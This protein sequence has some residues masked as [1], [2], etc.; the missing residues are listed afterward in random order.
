MVADA[1]KPSVVQL[2]P[3][4]NK[5]IQRH[6]SLKET[7]SSSAG[8]K[9]CFPILAVNRSQSGISED[10]SIWSLETLNSLAFSDYKSEVSD[11]VPYSGRT[12]T[13][14]VKYFSYIVVVSFIGGGNGSTSRTSSIYHKLLT[15]F[16][17]SSCIGDHIL[18]A[19]DFFLHRDL[20]LKICRYL[21]T[22]GHR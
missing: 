8:S 5:K 13:A 2:V 21:N 22:T 17:T 1:W 4:A 15:N 16:I 7:S 18:L 9:R 10:D 20:T 6:S 14:S 19:N 11:S 12:P 3:F